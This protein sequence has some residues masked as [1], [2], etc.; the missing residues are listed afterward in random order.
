MK[1]KNILFHIGGNQ[2][3]SDYKDQ[4]TFKIWQELS[5]SFDEYHVFAR[6]RN[7]R[8]ESFK[9]GNI[10]LH[11]IPSFG[12]RM[13]GFFF[14]SWFLPIYILKYKPNFLL[15]QCPVMGGLVASF[16]SLV[17]KIPLFVELHGTHYLK[18]AR[19]G[20]LG[21]VE[22]KFYKLLSKPTFNQAN[23]IRLLSEYM[24]NEFVEV[25]GSQHIRKMVV[26]PVRVDF[27]KFLPKDNYKSGSNIKIVNVG[28][29]CD[30]KNQIGLLKDI[31]NV[32]RNVEITFVG[33][34]EKHYDIVSYARDLPPNISVIL[35][36]Q[37]SHEEL[38]LLL[39]NSDIYVHYAKSEG[40]PRAI[41]EAMATG[42]PVILSDAGFM[43][44]L[45]IHKFNC[46]I[47][48]EDEKS[49]VV[50]YI[51]ELSSSESERVRLGKKGLKTVYE[52]FEW[53]TV[54]DL[55][56]DTLLNMKKS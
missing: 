2:Y 5:K 56:R 16:S 53:N 36:G 48:A 19:E 18:P 14:S 55:Y 1:N 32:K 28:R 35:A 31:K 33:S 43:N 34:G 22:H 10:H 37:V 20:L 51:E 54:F 8:F 12:S 7:M 11:L 6:N 9:N 15:T 17:F 3:G 4:H 45:L 49:R 42:L 38:N 40:T 46:L 30:N 24:L 26:I 25:Y 23:K 50:N 41:I 44:N 27:N 47:V 29:L 39:N 13:A 52:N 21:V